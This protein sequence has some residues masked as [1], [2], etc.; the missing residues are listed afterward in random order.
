MPELEQLLNECRRKLAGDDPVGALQDLLDRLGSANRDLRNEVLLHLSGLSALTSEER[1]GVIA[2]DAAVARRKRMV[3]AVLE[4]LDEVPGIVQHATPPAASAPPAPTTPPPST[5]DVFLSH[6][7]R[8]KVPVRELA[9]ALETR[10]V[11]V[12]L[13]EQQLTPGRPW[14]QE[15]DEIL[16][17]VLTAAI[18]VGPSGIGPWEEPEMWVCLDEFVQRR[19]PVIPV[20]LPGIAD[21]PQLPRFLR[22]FTWVD[23]SAGF[24]DAKLDALARA[25]TGPRDAA[26]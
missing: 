21:A 2:P 5:H 8:D 12:W 4:L 16:G 13:D 1:K 24:A 9:R 25:A 22:Q 23:L 19:M 14:L 17:R 10:G 26:S 6:N 15:L 18:L 20:L 3:L 11:R 7:S